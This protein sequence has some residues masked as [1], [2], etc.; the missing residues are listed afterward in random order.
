M[1]EENKGR[2]KIVAWLKGTRSRSDDSGLEQGGHKENE[3]RARLLQ[4]LKEKQSW[5]VYAALAIIVWVGAFIRTR[6]LRFLT[7]STTGNFVPLALDPHSF[8]RYA[9]IIVEQGALPAVDMARFV[10][11]GASTLKVAFVSHFIAAL[12][13]IWHVF[14]P[15]VTVEYVS[16][17]YPVVAF[18]I[19]IVFFFLLVRRLFD[20]RISLVATL[21]LSIMPAF[22]YRTMAGFADHEALGVMLMFMAMYVYVVGW[23]AKRKN[24]VWFGLGAGLL[25]GFMGLGWG[26][27][28]FLVLLIAGYT[29]VEYFFGRLKMG[30]MYQ[31]IAWVVGF[32]IGVT[33]FIPKFTLIDLASSFTTGS[34]FLVLGVLL[35]DYILFEKNLL[36][37]RS[38]LRSKFKGKIPESV[39][40]IVIVGV[41]GL[42]L[43]GAVL[44]FGTVTGQAGEIYDSLLH[45]LGNDRWELTVAEQHQPYFT[46]WIG[47]FGPQMLGFP[48]YLLLF[49]IGS[50]VVFHMLVKSEKHGL[51]YTLAYV[52]FLLS[53]TMSRYSRASE[54]FNGVSTTAKVFYLGSLLLFAGAIGIW[55]LK[56]YRE[57]EAAR[58]V[59]TFK[60]E[61]ILVLVWF[62]IMVVA[63]RG[64]VRLFFAFAPV[65]A[66]MAGVAVVALSEMA[67]KSKTNWVRIGGVAII[68]FVMLSPLGS[69]FTGIVPN[70]YQT[71]LGQSSQTGPSYNQQW[72]QTG[73]WVRENV[74]EDAVF[75]HWWDYGY[76]VQNGFERASVLDGQNRIKYWNFLMGRHVLTGQTQEEALEF[77]K[78]HETT[79]YLIVAD[80]IGKYTAYSSIG[81]DADRDRYSW[82]VPFRF[83]QNEVFETRNTTVLVYPGSYV[84]DDDFVWEGEVYPAQGSG[85]GGVLIPVRQKGEGL[86]FLQPNIQMVKNGQAKSVPLT[87]LMYDDKFVIFDGEGYDGCFRLVPTL[88]GNGVMENRYGAGLMIS[89][90]GRKALW[91][92]LYVFD[93]KNPQFV[94]S[95][96]KEVYGTGSVPL[97]MIN[98]RVIGPQ[99]IWEIEYPAGFSVDD[100]TRARYLG[101]NEYLPDY[102]FQVN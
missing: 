64:A 72:Q 63:A 79:H 10:P 70:Y 32:A 85:I 17:M 81:S 69:G 41:L 84:F 74:A 52:V 62:I 3:Q 50:I 51:W 33:T 30:D 21:L 86:E 88:G 8:T 29:L 34:A 48:L 54:V 22:L 59:S 23:K 28:K 92:N 15:S 38:L 40:V 78:V 87:C 24:K 76:W 26:G 42:V 65:T 27:W 53:F 19:G 35:V 71:S 43:G 67:W 82:I 68:L 20:W 14:D 25:T 80:E 73:A 95:A 98:G 39:I 9:R 102:F 99:K 31:Y 100:E 55:Y 83:N 6:N 1:S 56:R 45:P 58:S 4:T 57:G 46:D 36:K 47:Q 66:V 97:A 101:G 91:V 5:F 16:V 13:K 11:L 89:E 75:G 49:F 60:H 7:D 18:V 2:D 37:M 61:L 96:F 93:Q 77:L 12:Y 90:E 94:T 44:G